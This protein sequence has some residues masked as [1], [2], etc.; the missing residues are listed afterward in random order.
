MPIPPLQPFSFYCKNC[1]WSQSQQSDVIDFPGICP[2]CQS[3]EIGM[4]RDTSVSLKDLFL[5]IFIKTK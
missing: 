1:G 5:E 2:K 3:T 4:R